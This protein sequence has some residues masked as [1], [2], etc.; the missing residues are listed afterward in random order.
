MAVAAGIAVLLSASA[1]ATRGDLRELHQEMRYLSARQDS[2]FRAMLRVVERVNGQ[3]MDSVSALAE[4]LFEL[5]GDV[6]NRLHDIQKQQLVIGELV[7]QSQRSLA[8]MSEE[9]E[10]QSRQI[11]RASLGMAAADTLDPA[12]A[13]DSANDDPAVGRDT[14]GDLYEQAR[15]MFL[16]RG[17]PTGARRALQR[18][19]SEF[20]DSEVAPAAYLLLAEVLSVDDQAEEAIETYLMIP[21]LFPDADEVPRALF[22]AGLLCV[23]LDRNDE[24]REYLRWMLDSYPDHPLAPQA[25][26]RLAQIP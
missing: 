13:D 3:A 22:G 4:T 14:A 12:S 8:L 9:L 1:C 26:E 6:T 15:E 11:E 19:L 17:S 23:S 20:P 16:E 2:A 24:A 5:R 7:G 25:Q 10:Q 18:L 21:D